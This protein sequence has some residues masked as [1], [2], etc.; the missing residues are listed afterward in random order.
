MAAETVGPLSTLLAGVPDAAGAASDAESPVAKSA[1]GACGRPPLELLHA[2]PAATEANALHLEAKSLLAP[3]LPRER[4]PAAG[5]HHPVPRETP[6]TV[7]RPHGEASG[8]GVPGEG[9]QLTVRGDSAARDPGDDRADSAERTGGSG[10][11]PGRHPSQGPYGPPRT[12]LFSTGTRRCSS[13]EL[14]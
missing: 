10:P 11:T 3:L 14:R 9:R 6:A 4:D 5:G 12:C 7:E 13:E 1:G 8:A 2:D